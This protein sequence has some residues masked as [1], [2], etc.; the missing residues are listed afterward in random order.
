MQL[1]KRYFY[2][3]GAGV[4]QQQPS[5][6]GTSIS[7]RINILLKPKAAHKSKNKSIF[8]KSAPS[9]Q[10]NRA[11]T[12]HVLYIASKPFGPVKEKSNIQKLLS[13]IPSGIYIFSNNKHYY[14]L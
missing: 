14:Q 5:I 3:S 10:A 9:C 6:T 8:K 2:A 11:G 4:I 12:A 1:I 7:S 13:S